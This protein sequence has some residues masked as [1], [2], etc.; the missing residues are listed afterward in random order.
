MLTLSD[1]HDVGID[2]GYGC[3]NDGANDD[4]SGSQYGFKVGNLDNVGPNW[5]RL[6]LDTWSLGLQAF[7]MLLVIALATTKNKK[8]K[9]QT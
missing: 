5:G 2:R 3:D 7:C 1:D 4:V 9:P 6:A 8:C